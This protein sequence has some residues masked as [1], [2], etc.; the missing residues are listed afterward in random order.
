[1]LSWCGV[2]TAVLSSSLS[3]E[4]RAALKD[5]FGDYNRNM[6]LSPEAFDAFT[7]DLNNMF[8]YAFP[9]FSVIPLVLQ[10]LD[11]DQAQ[12]IL[13]VPNWP[14]QPWYLTL[15][16]LLIQQPVFLPKHKSNVILT[17]KPE[18]EH[19]L[20]TKLRLM[21]CLLSGDSSQTKAYHQRVKLQYLV[22][23]YTK[24]ISGLI[25]KWQSYANQLD[26]DPLHP[27][28][29]QV[30][31]FLQGLYQ[32]GLSYSGI[33]T[34]RSTLSV[35]TTLEGSFCAGMH[36]MVQQFMK[37]VLQARPALPRYQTTWDTLIV[38]SYLKAFYPVA[39]LTLQ[40]LTYK[41]VMLCVLVTGQRWQ[42]IHL[43]N[44]STLQ[45]KNHSYVFYIDQLVTQSG[46]GR[47]QPALVIPRFPSQ[48]S[49]ALL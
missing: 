6:H 39:E 24:T 4:K 45:K 8:F 13:I 31:D 26:A 17:L 23:R 5:S 44:L 15:T 28:L 41:L 36:P 19:P 1:M 43:M 12:A 14:T 10:K 32:Q 22:V 21:A 48:P 40:Q 34:A 9:P 33:N 29:N 37:G 38:L 47:K 7:L 49:F 16:K 11:M 46:P 2:W 42:S 27:T 20:G 35:F 25:H 3:G 30:L 18:K